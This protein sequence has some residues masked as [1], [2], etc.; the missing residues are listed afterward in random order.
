MHPIHVCVFVYIA[1]LYASRI[2]VG[3]EAIYIITGIEEVERGGY[4][5]IW[6]VLDLY[7]ELKGWL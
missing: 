5:S 7:V 6:V 4:R 1:D 2:I 3:V